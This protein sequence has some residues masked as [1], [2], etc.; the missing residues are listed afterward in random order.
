[1]VVMRNPKNASSFRN[2]YIIKNSLLVSKCD[3]HGSYK[4]SKECFQFS[5]SVLFKEEKDE[6][7]AD[8]NQ[9]SCVVKIK[10]KKLPITDL[11]R[12]EMLMVKKNRQIKAKKV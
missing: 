10:F 2:P 7:V 9:H 6:G 5:Q 12:V 3:S 11:K 1:M 8:G 4:K